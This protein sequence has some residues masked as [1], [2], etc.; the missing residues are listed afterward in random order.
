MT[1]RA[2]VGPT[3]SSRLTVSIETCSVLKSIVTVWVTPGPVAPEHPSVR[4]NEIKKIK[5]HQKGEAI[6]DI[7][8]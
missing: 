6:D 7:K 3:G 2:P 1:L 5:R 4:G 8:S